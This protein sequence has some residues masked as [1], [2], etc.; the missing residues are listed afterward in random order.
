MNRHVLNLQEST[1]MAIVGEEY[2]LFPKLKEWVQAK[3]PVCS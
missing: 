1:A 3:R 2:G